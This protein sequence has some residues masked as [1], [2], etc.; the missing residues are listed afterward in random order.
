MLNFSAKGP[1]AKEAKSRP[2]PIS[3]NKKPASQTGKQITK[4]P[5]SNQRPGSSKLPRKLSAAPS[6]ASDSASVTSSLKDQDNLDD[7]HDADIDTVSVSTDTSDRDTRSL[8]YGHFQQDEADGKVQSPI[9]VP[10]FRIMPPDILSETPYL[11]KHSIGIQVEDD[12][13]SKTIQ[14]LKEKGRHLHELV[15]QRTELCWQLQDQI[16]EDSLDFV[17]ASVMILSVVHKVRGNV[18]FWPSTM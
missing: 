11:S 10:S 17:S 12:S 8:S 14:A 16:D 18:F 1:L 5:P 15:K 7:L 9:E 4:Q 13:D 3:S 2:A 6:N